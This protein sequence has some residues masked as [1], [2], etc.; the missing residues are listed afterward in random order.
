[1]MDLPDLARLDDYASRGT[2]P[3]VYQGAVDG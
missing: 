1:M 2:K 3:C